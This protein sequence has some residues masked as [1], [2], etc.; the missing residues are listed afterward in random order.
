MSTRPNHRRGT[1]RV[2][3]NG[4]RWE[5]PTPNTGGPGV[6][7][8]RRGWKRLRAKSERRHEKR[9]RDR[10]AG[11]RREG[12]A[13]PPGRTERLAQEAIDLAL[14]PRP[15][16]PAEL[17]SAEWVRS[18]EEHCARPGRGYSEQWEVEYTARGEDGY[19]TAGRTMYVT[20]NRWWGEGD[21]QRFGAD[22]VRERFERD[23]ATRGVSEYRVVRV[24]YQ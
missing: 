8:G 21:D 3:D 20:P 6:A 16:S 22:L 23:M 1:P 13:R 11:E 17:A 9:A 24:Q 12:P 18:W 19:W 7:R 14:G 4:P 2:Q 5:G 10:A 15:L